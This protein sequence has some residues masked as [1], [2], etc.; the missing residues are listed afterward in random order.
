MKT[1]SIQNKDNFYEILTNPTR[2]NFRAFLKDNEFETDNIDFKQ[3]WIE[4]EKLT[5]IIL[6]MANS[7]GGVIIIGVTQNADNSFTPSGILG[8]IDS[9]EL[10]RE[11]KG[12]LPHT[13]KYELY[14]FNYDSSEYSKL[15]NKKFQLIAIRD[16][17]ANLPFICEKDGNT[18]KNGDVYIRKGTET[19]KATNEDMVRLIR[20]NISSQ[21]PKRQ[22]ISLEKHLLQLK[23]LYRELEHRKPRFI[24]FAPT[25][26]SLFGEP[27]IE[28]DK[29]YPSES[30]NQYIANMINKKK[31]RIAQELD[32]KP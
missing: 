14:S 4:K 31:E 16:N 25:L 20:R 29:E 32:V 5:K 11:I 28:K 24:M 1:N 13:L 19:Q 15:E 7:G 26:E 17:P 30:Y 22:A 10:Y 8:F 3:T 18:L 23:T 2:E 6:A 12:Y 21:P 9:S 27:E